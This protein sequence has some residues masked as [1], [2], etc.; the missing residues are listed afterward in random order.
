MMHLV[1]VYGTLRKGESNNFLLEEC[2]YLGEE[3]TVDRFVLNS[4]GYIP[5]VD[6]PSNHNVDRA[7]HIVGDLYL[8]HTS[9]QMQALDNLEGHPHSYCRELVRISD[10]REA[11][12]YLHDYAHS[13]PAHPDSNNLL[14]HPKARA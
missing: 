5:F 8:V 1:L 14:R 4:S 10:D 2:A 12:M 11:W 9:R 3:A 13:N 6:R 7:G